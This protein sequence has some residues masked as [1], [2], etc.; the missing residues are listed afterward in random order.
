[1]P[2]KINVRRLALTLL[3]GC[4]REGQYSNIALDAAI[5]KH[6]LT[7]A[8]RGLLT[9]LLFGVIEKQITLDYYI[10]LLSTLP[11]SKIEPRVRMLL[12]LGLYQIIFT[13]RIPDHAAVNESVALAPRRATRFVNALLRRYL[14]ERESIALPRKEEGLPLYLSVKYS[15]PAPLCERF[16]CIFGAE[17]AEALLA[18]FGRAPELTL[19]VNTLKTTRKDYLARL[20]DARI[21]ASPTPLSPD[22]VS[23]ATLP[24]ASLPGFNDGLFF[25]QDEASQLAVRA[26]DAHSGMTVVDACAAPGSKSFGAA[27]AMGNKGRIFSFDLHENKLSLILSSAGRLGIDI[28]EVSKC[29]ARNP[30]TQLI[31]A[32]DRVICDVPCSGYGVMAKKPEIRY[33][34][35][36]DAALLPEIQFDILENCSR[37][38][39][40]GGLLVYSTCTIL[41]EENERVVGRFLAA[42]PEFSLSP[43][44]AGSLPVPEGMITLAPDTHST[45]G[46]FIARMKRS[47]S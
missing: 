36:A 20:A 46:F 14:R 43:F 13:D 25:V 26:L 30:L 1:M 35:L 4:E 29:D 41:P 37:Y 11:P 6:N 23:L 19:C 24:L 27:L 3:L 22:G 21:N 39:A 10:D 45:D 8:D 15:F 40:P 7:P 9:L 5:K 44:T 16:T 34:N 47:S 17:R 2:E 28:I 31:G 42:H 33:K 38:T 18:A 32:A 12:R